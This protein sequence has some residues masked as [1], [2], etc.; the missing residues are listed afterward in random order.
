MLECKISVTD[1]KQ[2]TRHSTEV[3]FAQKNTHPPTPGSNHS[4]AKD[5]SN[6]FLLT[7]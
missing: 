6:Y 4:T 2:P 7:L 5:F 3:V 1:C